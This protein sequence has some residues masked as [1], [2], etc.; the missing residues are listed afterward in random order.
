M[1]LRGD[2]NNPAW[3]E[4]PAYDLPPFPK[5][6]IGWAL[7]VGGYRLPGPASAR[8]WYRDTSS[9]FEPPGALAV[10]RL[11]SVVLGALG[12]LAIYVLGRCARDGR[13][14]GLAALFLMLNPLY[15][16]HARWAMSD[17]PAEAFILMALAG[18]LWG[19]RRWLSG[20]SGITA[21]F[22]AVLAGVFCG[23]AALSKLN[24]RSR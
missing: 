5:Y 4:Y 8:L 23:L 14:G 18:G 10:A 17:V 16:L 22:S 13:V 12:C 20:R 7:K 3:L 15:R 9:R 6:L 11:P 1:L 19:W 24:G 21:W 2:F